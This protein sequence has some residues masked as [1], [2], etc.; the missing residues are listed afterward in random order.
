MNDKKIDD[1]KNKY[2]NINV[3]DRLENMV[4]ETIN[5]SRRM[6]KKGGHMKKGLIG[7]AASITILVGALNISPAFAGVLEDV[8]VVGKIIKLIVIKNKVVWFK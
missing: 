5:N 6:R 1:L 3:P 7:L 8:P 2:I 4:Y